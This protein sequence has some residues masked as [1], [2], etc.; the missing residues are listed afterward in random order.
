[1][2]FDEIDNRIEGGDEVFRESRE[3]GLS[4]NYQ[5]SHPVLKHSGLLVRLVPDAAVMRN[6]DP[7]SIPDILKPCRIGAVVGK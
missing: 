3:R 7:T 5:E 2:A 4:D 6:G 1:M